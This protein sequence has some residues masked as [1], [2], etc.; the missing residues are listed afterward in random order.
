MPVQLVWSKADLADVDA[1]R[2]NISHTDSV[3][4]RRQPAWHRRH[5]RDD[6]RV[7]CPERH[8][9]FVP[10]AVPTCSQHHRSGGVG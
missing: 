5:A 8:Q 6:R 4:T 9:Y 1:M 10:Y 3:A 7:V 2:F